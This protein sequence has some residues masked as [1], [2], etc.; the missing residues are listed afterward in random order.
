MLQQFHASPQGLR[1]DTQLSQGASH[2]QDLTGLGK[3]KQQCSTMSRL[4]KEYER[5]TKFWSYIQV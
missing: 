2:C 3:L 5:I 4:E 1:P